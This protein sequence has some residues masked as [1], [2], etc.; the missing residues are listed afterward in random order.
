MTSNQNAAMTRIDKTAGH[1]KI[2]HVTATALID[3][4]YIERLPKPI[5]TKPEPSYRFTRKGE[6]W[7]AL[8][9]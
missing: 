9:S 5:S 8:R 7:I 4:G 6:K 2:L 3:H 1:C